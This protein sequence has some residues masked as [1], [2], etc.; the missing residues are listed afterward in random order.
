MGPSHRGLSGEMVHVTVIGFDGEPEVLEFAAMVNPRDGATE[1]N[2]I[3]VLEAL[4]DVRAAGLAEEDCERVYPLPRG[5]VDVSRVGGGTRPRATLLRQQ[6]GFGCERF[7]LREWSEGPAERGVLASAAQAVSRWYMPQLP[8]RVICS[9]RNC[10]SITPSPACE[11]AIP[12]RR[13]GGMERF[14]SAWARP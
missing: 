1:A 11:A 13:A 6:H 12:Q 5:A 14:S 8:R 3:I 4:I 7:G 2:Y 10:M 9:A